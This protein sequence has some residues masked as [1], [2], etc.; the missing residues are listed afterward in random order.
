[1]S[2]IGKLPITLPDNV[3]VN[4]SQSEFIVKG[5]FGTLQ[6]KIPDII[7]ITQDDKTLKVNLKSDS[8]S[9]RSLHGLYRTLINNMI[10]GVSEQFQLTL[11]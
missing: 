4:Y 1:M 10:I 2:R 3:D 7:I 9:D 5:K 6:T 8:G 11:Y